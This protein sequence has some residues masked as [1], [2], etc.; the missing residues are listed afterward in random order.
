[1]HTLEVDDDDVKVLDILKINVHFWC[2]ILG[3]W[4]WV[5]CLVLASSTLCDPIC[6]HFEIYE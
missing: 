1:M 3:C 6:G 2:K 5:G 4:L